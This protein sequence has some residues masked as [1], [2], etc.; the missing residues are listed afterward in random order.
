METDTNKNDLL[1][2]G[3]SYHDRGAIGFA[4]FL[5]LFGVILLLFN[6]GIIP[7]DYKPI[8]ISWQ[9]LLIVIGL[10]SLIKRNITSGIILILIGG[11]FIYPKLCHLFPEYLSCISIDIRT[12]WPILLVV[13]GVILIFKRTSSKNTNFHINE[14]HEWTAA[15]R[16]QTNGT[17]FSDTDYIDKNKMF[18]SSHQIVLSDNFKGG[19]GNIMFGELIIDLRKAK[20]AD[21][22]NQLELNVMFGSIVLY[23]PDDWAIELKSSSIFGSFEDKRHHREMPQSNAPR[24]IVKGSAMFGGGEIKN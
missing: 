1:K 19:E 20:L 18:G 6:L 22:I 16:D 14:R 11:F 13:V 4:L 21:G 12:Y 7:R 15:D 24:L 8:L 5:V 9:M 3:R 2:R 17:N 10:W 23:V